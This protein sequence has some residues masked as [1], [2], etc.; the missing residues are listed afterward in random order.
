MEKNI[1]A[2]IPCIY[3]PW[4]QKDNLPGYAELIQERGELRV[5]SPHDSDGDYN[6]AVHEKDVFIINSEEVTGG[7]LMVSS[8]ISR[9]K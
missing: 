6:A 2:R 7:E 4:P 8:E 3:F 5:T 1:N 9:I